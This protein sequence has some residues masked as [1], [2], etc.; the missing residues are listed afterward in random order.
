MATVYS[1]SFE[2]SSVII[3]LIA[4]ISEQIGLMG[5]IPESVVVD[6]IKTAN[7]D[8]L[9]HSY[10]SVE[11]NSLTLEQVGAILE[12]NYIS[13][14]PE[15]V[16]TLCSTVNMYD[17]FL[18]LSPSSQNDLLFVHNQLMQ[19]RVPDKLTE[20][21]TM[22]DISSPIDEVFASLRSLLL[23]LKGVDIHPLLA[24]CLIHYELL[25]L[26]AFRKGNHNIAQLWQI[27]ILSKWR[28]T[29]ALL[30]L[31]ALLLDAES[32]Y[33]ERFWQA[34]NSGRATVFI[35]FILRTLLVGL[36]SIAPFF[37]L[38]APEPVPAVAEAEPSSPRAP[39]LS[40]IGEQVKILVRAVATDTSPSLE[41]MKRL[42]LKHRPTFLYNYLR[43]ALEAG[44]VEMIFP[45]TPRSR[46]QKYRLTASGRD[47]LEQMS[48]I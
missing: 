32:E 24:S 35:E 11:K 38:P 21:S 25:C 9:V 7:R 6:E 29:F 27:L 1:P 28:K 48:V 22:M 13:E 23:W 14:L 15:G 3:D 4:S 34:V 26:K 41:L 33:D 16:K 2:Y 19:G 46:N 43:P 10:L 18:G 42:G 36:K 20:G 40:Q 44:V 45:Q 17:S 30:P 5:E 31:S 8:R 12:G 39:V 37:E 47:L